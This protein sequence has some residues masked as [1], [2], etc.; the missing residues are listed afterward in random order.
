VTRTVGATN[1]TISTPFDVKVTCSNL[2]TLLPCT[3]L[4]TPSYILTAQLQSNDVTNTW[5]VGGVVLTSSTAST[6]TNSGTYGAVTPY[7]FA[8]TIPF[9]ESSGAISNT[10]DFMSVCN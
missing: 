6:V 8:L 5:K 4:I 3:L 10:V 2:L 7:T 9:S 1:W